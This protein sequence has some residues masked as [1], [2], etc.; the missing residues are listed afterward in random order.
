M[1][2]LTTS[3]A[4]TN[5]VRVEVES[6]YHPDRSAPA[7]QRWFFSYAIRITN[8]GDQTVQLI[9]RHWIITDGTG[10]V[11]EVMGEG[12]VGQQPVLKPGE[13]FLYTSFCP[14]PTAR[15]SMRGT[16]QMVLSNGEQI[17][18]EIAPFALAQYTVH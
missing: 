8:L 4:V 15:G 18:V 10:H 12:V 16:Y 1:M 2:E 3:A 7:Q 13:S 9:S 5:G 11:E 17:D 14:L 6:T